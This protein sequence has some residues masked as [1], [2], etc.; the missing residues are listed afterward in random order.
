MEKPSYDYKCD[1]ENAW[2]FYNHVTHSYKSVHPRSWLSDTK[3]FHD[4]MVANVLNGMGVTPQDTVNTEDTIENELVEEELSNQLYDVDDSPEVAVDS[5][6]PIAD[7][8]GNV[9]YEEIDDEEF[10][11]EI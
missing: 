8:I 10:D 7:S 4:F 6:E 9:D 1:Q 3:N 11:F 2:A 5:E